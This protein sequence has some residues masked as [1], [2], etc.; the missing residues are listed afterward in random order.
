MKKYGLMAA[1]LLAV[2]LLVGGGS[3]L[4]QKNAAESEKWNNENPKDTVHLLIAAAASLEYSLR[5]E[6]IPMFEDLYPDI[7]V[8]GTYDSSGKLQLQIEEGLDAD[9]FFSAAPKQMENLIQEDFILPDTRVD[10][11]QNKLVL[12][13]PSDTMLGLTKFE[14]I[15]KAEMIAIGDPN[16][17][18]VGQYAK[19]AL[20]NL[21]IWEEVSKKASFGTN[22]TEVLS[23]VAAGSA[24][25]GIVYAT[26]AIANPMGIKVISEAPKDSLKSKVIYPVAI[27]NKLEQQEGILMDNNQMD[28]IQ[29]DSIQLDA[30]K[31]FLEFL[32]SKKAM[33]VFKKY[34]FTENIE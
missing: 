19:E 29:K 11:L 25:A 15:G 22:V 10:L 27:V 1:G 33:E 2:I 8:E 6:L 24:D 32:S 21:G 16:S 5:D 23:W 31:K 13:V 34:G 12:I 4:L 28:N 17:V 9:I 7:T 14:E 20:T 3:F 18:P 26:D 30:A